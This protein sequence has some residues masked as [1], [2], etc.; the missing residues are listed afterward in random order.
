MK[1]MEEKNEKADVE[2]KD[3]DQVCILYSYK[4]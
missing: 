2:I 4:L 3:F 1:A